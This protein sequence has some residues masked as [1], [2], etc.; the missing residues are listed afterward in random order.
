MVPGTARAGTFCCADGAAEEVFQG[1]DMVS[2][3][4]GA[5][6]E[7]GGVAKA[8]KVRL[9]R[10]QESAKE[11]LGTGTHA[12][13]WRQVPVKPLGA[14]LPPKKLL[15]LREIRGVTKSFIL[16]KEPSYCLPMM[17]RSAACRLS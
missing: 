10:E 3:R 6:E 16:F 17:Y 7:A 2:A 5:G 1:S 13:A 4:D 14:G 12:R 8:Y 9:L 11:V 15:A